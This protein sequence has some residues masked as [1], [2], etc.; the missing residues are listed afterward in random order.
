M[1]IFKC[2]INNMPALVSIMALCR[3]DI[4]LTIEKPVSE[5][6]VAKFTGKYMMSLKH[7]IYALHFVG[8]MISFGTLMF[9]VMI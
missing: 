6:M 5:A 9:C 2:P 4:I 8:R 7:V 3:T 1:K